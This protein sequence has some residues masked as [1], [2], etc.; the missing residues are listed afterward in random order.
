MGNIPVMNFIMV[1]ARI[2]HNATVLAINTF[3]FINVDKD[4]VVPYCFNRSAEIN[5]V[6]GFKINNGACSKGFY[7]P[8][9]FLTHTN[10]IMRLA[11]GIQL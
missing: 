1:C 7:N 6:A 10:K 9:V 8:P 5:S 11:K 3:N 4:T 2:R